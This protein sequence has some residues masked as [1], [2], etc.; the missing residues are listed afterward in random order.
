MPP[1]GYFR[2]HG[3]KNTLTAL[4]HAESVCDG[5][6]HVDPLHLNGQNGSVV[7]AVGTFH[8]GF[9]FNCTYLEARAA[10]CTGQG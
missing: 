7:L 5:E 4:V 2:I 9:H 10:N 6:L 1:C 8:P 3:V